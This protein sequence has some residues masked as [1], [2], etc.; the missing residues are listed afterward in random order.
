M[1]RH[2]ACDPTLR[3]TESFLASLPWLLTHFGTLGHTQLSLTEHSEQLDVTTLG[4]LERE[5]P[6]QDPDARYWH[7]QGR[8]VRRLRLSHLE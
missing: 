4:M 5:T 7:E 3:S 8:G 1:P 2:N 6:Y